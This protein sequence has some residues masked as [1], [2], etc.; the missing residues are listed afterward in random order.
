MRAAG[1]RLAGGEHGGAD[2]LGHPLGAGKV[3]VGQQH[4]E[5]FAA[6]AAGKVAGAPDAVVDAARDR[7]QH[8][9]ARGVAIAVVVVLEFVDVDHQHRE[10]PA[11]PVGA[12][13]LRL[14]RRVQRAARAQAGQAVGV[15]QPCQLLLGLHAPAQLPGEQDRHADQH[16]IQ[17]QHDPADPPGPLAPL[18]VDVVEGQ[19]HRED[20]RIVADAPVAEQ[21]LHAIDGP[22]DD[23][24]ARR[25]VLAHLEG[26]AGGQVAADQVRVVRAAHQQ[27]AVGAD[28]RDGGVL[29]QAHAVEQ[30]PEVVEPQ[31]AD[32]DAVEGAVRSVQALADAD[33][34][35]DA[36]DAGHERL[37]QVQADIRR[38]LLDLEVI[39]VADVDAPGRHRARVDDDVAGGVGD[40]QRAQILRVGRAVEQHQL[41]D[42]R[43]QRQDGRVP[44]AIDDRLHRQ[45]VDFEVA[46]NVPLQD[47]RDVVGG[48][49]RPCQR[50]HP[51][52]VER[53]D[54]ERRH[55]RRQ[56][57]GAD[58]HQGRASQDRASESRQRHGLSFTNGVACLFVSDAAFPRNEIRFL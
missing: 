39:A 57:E 27:R 13:P 29:A 34:R 42:R 56:C 14:Q 11:L 37:A 21:P 51:H 47:Q 54:G 31:R 23:Q 1:V 41:P 58:D 16:G 55:G 45:F 12:L 5:F 10:R 3:G 19:P 49:A 36:V 15:G 43:R 44:H 33:R 35:L 20:Q 53:E 9:I 30:P 32:H 50:V 40:Q 46:R 8:G 17:Q 26:R 7:A 6:V 38:L 22:G 18:R 24:T 4:A 2:D 48:I 52:F 25:C 28:Q